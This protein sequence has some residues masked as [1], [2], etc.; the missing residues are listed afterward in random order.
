MELDEVA[1]FVRVVQAGS[2]SKAADE[3]GAPR[4]TVSR[5]IAR[6]EARLGVRL[7]ER[8][9]RKM[10]LTE[11]GAAYFDQVSPAVAAIQEADRSVVEHGA[12]PRGTLR[13]SAPVDLGYSLLPALV[14]RFLERYPEVVVDLELS[15]RF[16]DL[17]AEGVDVALRAGQ[18]ADS[19]LVARRIGASD[20][21]LFASPSHLARRGPPA[22]P[23]ALSERACVTRRG[24]G[25]RAWKLTHPD[26]RTVEVPVAAVARA[27][28][29]GFLLRAAVA[30]AGIALL[31]WI[32]A[33]AEVEAG[34]LVR[35]LEPWMVHGAPLHAVSTPGRNRSPKVRAFIDFITRAL[36]R[37]PD[38]ATPPPRGARRGRR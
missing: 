23:E 3:L 35:I 36:S 37:E 8:T 15:N 18:L 5:Q 4:S 7:I 6:L 12:R 21:F 11:E 9:T 24:P 25:A 26:G 10:A 31:P 20:F 22:T 14:V 17:V 28:D 16:V 2:M 38:L 32:A 29:F 13:V 33:R 1:A 34:R 27:D 30:G 19:T